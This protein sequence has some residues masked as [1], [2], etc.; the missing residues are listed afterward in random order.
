MYNRD[1]N[2]TFAKGPFEEVISLARVIHTS[3]IDNRCTC[4][5]EEATYMQLP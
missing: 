2:L 1:G 4:T 5:E 3:L